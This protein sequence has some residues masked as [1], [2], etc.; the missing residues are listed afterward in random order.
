MTIGRMFI[1][2]TVLIQCGIEPVTT[3]VTLMHSNGKQAY[4]IH[5]FHMFSILKQ[6]Y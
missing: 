3:K 6:F 4:N 5:F 2:Y 1:E